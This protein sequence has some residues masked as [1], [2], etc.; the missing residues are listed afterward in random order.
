MMDL[1]GLTVKLL[2]AWSEVPEVEQVVG[3][4]TKRSQSSMTVEELSRASPN[5]DKYGQR[6]SDSIEEN[7]RPVRP[8]AGSLPSSRMRRPICRIALAMAS[9]RRIP[10]L[11]QQ[12]VVHSSSVLLY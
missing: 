10:S 1:T 4:P 9:P 11:K 8:T 12:V 6:R 3:S 5:S 7:T 2:A